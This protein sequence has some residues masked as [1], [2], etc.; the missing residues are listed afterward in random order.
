MTDTSKIKAIQHIMATLFSV[1]N[2]LRELAPDYRWAGLGNL[3]GDYGEFVAMEAY[4]LTKA[5]AGSNGFDAN[6]SDGRTVQI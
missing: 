4:H 6:T 3:L 2:A 5:P 1:Q